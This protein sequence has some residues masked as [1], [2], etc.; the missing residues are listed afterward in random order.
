[1]VAFV[2]LGALAL[3]AVRKRAARTPSTSSSGGA[4]PIATQQTR[5]VPARPALT[6]G[7]LPSEPRRSSGSTVTVAGAA[8]NS[9][10]PQAQ[11]TVDRSATADL[12]VIKSTLELIPVVGSLAGA[13]VGGLS[14]ALGVAEQLFTGGSATDVSAAEN[15]YI[16]ANAHGIDRSD[17]ARRPVSSSLTS[18]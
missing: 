15:A 14:T 11:G 16:N 4:V 12:G 10:G 7:D 17:E 9:G 3:L 13:A 1:M 8:A 5:T 2:A 18:N 6:S